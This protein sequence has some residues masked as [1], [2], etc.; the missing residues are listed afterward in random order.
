MNEIKE[1]LVK[2]SKQFECDF[3]LYDE[4]FNCVAYTRERLGFRND[5]QDKEAVVS[6]QVGKHDFHIVTDEKENRDYLMVVAIACK[7]RLEKQREELSIEELIKEAI[8]DT[9]TEEELKRCDQHMFEDIYQ[10]Y[11]IKPKQDQER[12]DDLKEIFFIDDE[13]VVTMDDKTIVL[14]NQMEPSELYANNMLSDFRKYKLDCSIV[15]GET[16]RSASELHQSVKEL[17]DVFLLGQMFYEDKDILSSNDLGVSYLVSKL[18]QNDLR[19]ISGMWTKNSY[20]LITDFDIEFIT[21]FLSCNL[22]IY[23]TANKLVIA[24]DE[25]AKNI[26][27]INQKIHLNILN[28]EDA[29]KVA[30]LIMMKKRIEE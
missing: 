30:L 13:I 9:L 29:M 6:F 26:E 1:L 23:D 22:S 17:M 28:F 25:V 10:L 15:F 7:N 20:E 27:K 24:E 12:F 11:I 3:F 2:Y 14:A 16:I 18:S 4:A 21:T 19:K 8:Q 5:N